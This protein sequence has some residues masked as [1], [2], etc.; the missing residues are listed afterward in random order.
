MLIVA[1]D[2]EVR[3]F[4]FACLEADMDIKQLDDTLALITKAEALMNTTNQ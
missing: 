1:L 3:Q 2:Q 4:M